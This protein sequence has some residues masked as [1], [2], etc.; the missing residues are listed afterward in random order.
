MR[1]DPWTFAH[2]QYEGKKRTHVFF[3]PE[4][5]ASELGERA[6]ATVRG[7]ASSLSLSGRG[8]RGSELFAKRTEESEFSASV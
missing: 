8:Q 2:S 1:R 5:G 4:L 6:G 7:K 3:F